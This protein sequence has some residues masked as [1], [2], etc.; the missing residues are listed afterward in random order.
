MPPL[1]QSSVDAQRGGIRGGGLPLSAPSGEGGALGLVLYKTSPTETSKS[2]QECGF[3]AVVRG[4]ERDCFRLNPARSRYWRLHKTVVN[5]ARLHECGASAH[6]FRVYR[7]F[8]TLTYRPGVDWS[9]RHVSNC[10]EAM[11]Q[12]MRRKGIPCRY[13][14]VMELHKSGIP[15][16][17]VAVWLPRGFRLPMFDRRGWWSHGMTNVKGVHTPAG[18]LAKYLSKADSFAGFPKGARA[19]GV[20][21]LDEDARR[22]CR[23]WRAPAVVRSFFVRADNP[24]MPDLVRVP[25]GW[26]D[27]RTGEFDPARWRV[28][29]VTDPLLS[30]LTMVIVSTDGD[31]RAGGQA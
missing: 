7:A 4:V 14:W 3:R 25:G 23:F 2:E 26:V 20:C 11:S 1:D 16:Y 9:P 13:V 8:I 24:G 17:H 18:Y 21:G 12:W 10:L 6:G 31:A 19:Y 5:A 22:E 28:A 15:H 29:W 27:R 30:V